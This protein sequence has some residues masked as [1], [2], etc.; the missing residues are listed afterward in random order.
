MNHSIRSLVSLRARLG[1]LAAAVAVPLVP[2]A[3]ATAATAVA[4]TFNPVNHPEVDSPP[5]DQLY[6]I[7]ALSATNIWAVG[8]SGAA[9]RPLVEHYNGTKWRIVPSP[10]KGSTTELYDVTVLGAKNAWAVGYYTPVGGGHNRTLVEHWNGTRWVVVAS[11]NPIAASDNFL[12]GVDAVS[13]TNIWAV[14]ANGRPGNK[15]V[16][17]HFNGTKWVTVHGASLAN[18]GDLQD[19]SAISRTNIVAV[20]HAGTSGG[21]EALVERFDGSNWAR[22]TV[23][24]VS[25]SGAD[26]IG[27]STPSA[28]AQWAVGSRSG[29]AALQTLTIRNTGSGWDVVDSPNVGTDKINFFN[30]VSAVAAGNAWAVGERDSN[31][32]VRRT[33][34]AHFSSG[35]W[36]VVS[37]PNSG[38][39]ANRL[40]GVATPTGMNIWAVGTANHPIGST[41]LVEHGC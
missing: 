25:G 31:S 10:D 12:K 2:S 34:L 23:P 35:S 18:G 21:N 8:S 40:F 11:P 22:E 36:S 27:V 20:G 6:G 14:G 29:T 41:G 15:T 32:F 30:D 26:L 9:G 16:I 17:E 5:F 33:L 24:P 37:S 4:C 7:D 3:S 19:V 13:A 39:A 28:T 1:F 38:T